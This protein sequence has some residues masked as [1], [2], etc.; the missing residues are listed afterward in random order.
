MSIKSS[1]VCEVTL[2]LSSLGSGHTTPLYCL[3]VLGSSRAT[4]RKV[5]FVCLGAMAM[6]FQRTLCES[7]CLNAAVAPPQMCI[8]SVCLL[9]LRQQSHHPKC[10]LCLSVLG[11]RYATPPNAD[12]HPTQHRRGTPRQTDRLHAMCPSS[13]AR[14]VYA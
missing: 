14:L 10:T 1:D 9:A 4:L 5:V 11:S 6:P 12:R 13:S 2:R 8:V 7:V 3:S